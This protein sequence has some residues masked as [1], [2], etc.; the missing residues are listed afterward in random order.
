MISSVSKEGGQAG[1]TLVELLVIIAVLG[2]LATFAIPAFS[3]WLPNYRLGS[4]ARN[5]Y[6]N[7]QWARM[8]AIKNN[9]DWAIVFN[10]AVTPGTYYIC[11]NPGANGSWDGPAAMG[12]DDTVA[13]A[14]DFATFEPGNSIDFGH[15]NR[16]TDIPG[17]PYVANDDVVYGANDAVVFNARGSCNAGYVYIDNGKDRTYAIGTRISGGI[18]IRKWTGSA[19][20]D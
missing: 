15:G 16:L 20:V 13:R 18:I 14:V 19:W 17:N 11:S 4:A 6:S 8:N 5:M 7:F 2:I 10:Q 12:G 9:Q 1:F 3:V